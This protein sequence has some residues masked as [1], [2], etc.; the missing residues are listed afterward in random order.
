MPEETEEKI[1]LLLFCE[2]AV[3]L[4]LMAYLIIIFF[5][6]PFYMQNGY[7]QIGDAK[8]S[9]YMDITIGAFALILPLIGLCMMLR[10]KKTR[11]FTR[12]KTFSFTDCAFLLYGMAVVL[13]YF[14][15]QFKQKAVWGEEGWYMG[16]L[17]QLLFILSYFIISRFWEFEEKILLAFIVA[18]AGVFLLGLLNRFSV[19][20]IAVE[21]ATREFIS[22]LGNINWYCGYFA[23][24]FPIGFVWYWF[25]DKKWL[26]AAVAL[27]VS[28]GIATGVTQGSNSAFIAIVG[29]Y[30]VLFCL[31][32]RSLKRMKCFFEL[33]L[34]FCVVCQ[35]LRIWRIIL[36]DS[37]DYYDGSLTDWI[38]MTHAT[39]YVMIPLAVVYLV[40]I[41]AEK[42]KHMDI[43]RYKMLRQ[44][45][46]LVLTITGGVY[47]M[48]LILNTRT[49]G[50][51]RFM[52]GL[53]ALIF[54]EY[55]GSSRGGTWS[56]GVHIFQRIPGLRKL[57][58]VGP[59]CFAS[60]LY[61]L[62]DVTE[63]V[64]DQFGTS[65]LTNA[66]NE[67]LTVLVNNG[68]A[69]L[70]GYAGIF[71]SVWIRF[72]YRAEKATVKLKEKLTEDKRQLYLYIFA[73]SSFIYTIHNIVSFQQILS[74]PF[75]FLMIGMG[76]SLMREGMLKNGNT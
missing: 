12:H 9:F 46:L 28:L 25:T 65:R 32:F 31:S 21:G 5:F 38:T 57:I 47:I 19:Y 59:D 17:T 67:W 37:F 69:G 15:S 54:S 60:Y 48:L 50:G 52:G 42:K 8:F 2:E 33:S 7:V 61:I 35:A 3:S 68:I 44:I 51:I 49:H 18:S 30:L 16:L 66:H 26:K 20:P 53:Q 6:Y 40:I 29:L 27:Y 56:A 71:A 34:L 64:M 58:G 22:T 63:K 24:L 43:G 55:W 13:S 45:T 1:N 10:F 23:V 70:I 75:V 74:T 14:F 62:P 39:L 76:E 11:S 36:P 4:L 73:I 41:L 72:I